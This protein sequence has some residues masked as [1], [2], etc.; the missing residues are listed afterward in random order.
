MAIELMW[1]K[2]AVM[3]S[4]VMTT[5]ANEYYLAW[6][7]SAFLT[8]R[9]IIPVELLNLECAER[10]AGLIRAAVKEGFDINLDARAVAD[11]LFRYWGSIPRLSI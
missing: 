10:S 3:P 7:K 1:V 4:V 2:G 5:S 11:Y 6:L 8:G 9:V